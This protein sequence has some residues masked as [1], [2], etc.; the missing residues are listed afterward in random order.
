M[1]VQNLKAHPSDI[2]RRW[3][4]RRWSARGNASGRGACR[5]SFALKGRGGLPPLQGE[6]SL[7]RYPG[8]CPGLVTFAPTARRRDSDSNN[9][10]YH[11]SIYEMAST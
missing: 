3:K 1:D 8:R 10:N 6:P 5:S 11:Q 9:Q 7:A 4:R 2:F